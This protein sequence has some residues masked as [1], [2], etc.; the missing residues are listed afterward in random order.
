MPRSVTRHTGAPTPPPSATA[1]G[2]RPLP[3]TA[4]P[5]CRRRRRRARAGWARS[6]GPDE[7]PAGLP[8]AVAALGQAPGP[9]TLGGPGRLDRVGGVALAVGPPGLA[10][11]PVDLNDFE[12]PGP[13]VAGQA[14]AIGAGALHADP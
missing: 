5:R 6:P 13:Q 12:P 14:S 3:P 7:R 11:G 1:R 9:S 2:C 10:V 4:T 8:V